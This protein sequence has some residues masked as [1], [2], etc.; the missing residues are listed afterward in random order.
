MPLQIVARKRF[1]PAAVAAFT[2]FSVDQLRDL[3]KRGYGEETDGKWFDADITDIARLFFVKILREQNVEL[4]QAWKLANDE[5][6]AGIV[7]HAAMEPGAFQDNSGKVIKD[8]NQILKLAFELTG[9]RV[10]GSGLFIWGRT[11]EPNVYKSADQA[12]ELINK[13][14]SGP[15]VMT[16]VDMHEVGGILFGRIGEPIATVE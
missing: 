11:I 4:A 16:I 14:L 6:V 9:R 12:R 8:K 1:Q 3:R 15:H 5:I 13:R 2:G 7:V 10:V